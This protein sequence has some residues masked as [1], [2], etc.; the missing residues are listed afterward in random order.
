MTRG[1]DALMN[2]FQDIHLVAGLPLFAVL[3][4]ALR[5]SRR[6]GVARV[7][8]LLFAS[9]LLQTVLYLL[10]FS[11]PFR[12]F[13]RQEI[14][15]DFAYAVTCVFLVAM[16]VSLEFLLKER[17]RH[18]ERESKAQAELAAKVGE[19]T[20]ELT[21]ANEELQRTAARLQAEI[22]ERKRVQSQMEKNHRDLIEV[23]RQAGMSEVAT[24]VLH[25]V[26][27]VLNSVNVSANLLTDHLRQFKLEYISRVAQMLRENSGN[28]G[29]YLTEDEK[30]RQ[31][32][33][34][35][36]K[37]ADQ[38]DSER[39]MLI[40]ESEFIRT[41][42][43]HIKE[44]VA[45]QQNYGRVSGAAQ[46]IRVIDVVED[47][48]HI[49]ASELE[50][51]NVRVQRDYKTPLPEVIVD[52]H[53]VLAILLNLVSNAKHACVDSGRDGKQVNVR[54][55]NGD[56]KIRIMVQDNGVGIPAANLNKIFNHGFTTRK[57]NGHGFGLHSGALAAK[58]IGGQLTAQSDGPEK[59]ATFTLELP[60]K[61]G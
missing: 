20:T 58:E 15:M 19:Q 47:V 26:G 22:D 32:P 40:K 25:N 38:L 3:L 51:H 61:P 56:D 49:H 44:I 21:K 6:F 42:I 8:W 27:N 34:F 59:G 14:K 46:K 36:T 5:L 43:E 50:E 53:K 12:D 16:M 9:F 23:T 31:I 11:D 24:G 57:H 45:T 41:K 10:F 54:V 17:A 35:L 60:L 39:T 33:L 29:R 55:T 48:L 13:P 4:Y 7:G 28:L 37:L 52:K 1:F 18:L 30:G 2:A